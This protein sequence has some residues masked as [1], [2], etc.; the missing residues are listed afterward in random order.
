VNNRIEEIKERLE[1]NR[2]GYH[3][4]I[5][6]DYDYL[7]SKL[8]QAEKALELLDRAIKF[9]QETKVPAKEINEF[10]TG[11]EIMIHHNHVVQIEFLNKAKQ[12]A[13]ESLQSIR[14]D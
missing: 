7:L 9:D 14:E 8:E 2:N 3:K 12:A 10:F 1:A 6:D 13:K 4:Q 11:T 5:T